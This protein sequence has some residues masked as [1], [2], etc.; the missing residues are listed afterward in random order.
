VL[1][2]QDIVNTT[3][4]AELSFGLGSVMEL[5]RVVTQAQHERPAHAHIIGA[6]KVRFTASQTTSMTTMFR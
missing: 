2:V 6:G 4:K 3:F 5:N 1:T